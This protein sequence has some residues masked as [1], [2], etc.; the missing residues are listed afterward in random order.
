MDSVLILADIALYFNNQ[1]AEAYTVRGD[2]Y[3]VKGIHKKAIEEYDKAIKFNPNDWIAYYGKGSLYAHDDLVKWIDNFQ[4]AASL[5]HGS[6]LPFLLRGIGGVYYWAGFT[7]KGNY[8]TQEALK[9]DGD[10][11]TYY[12]SLAIGT[13]DN[14]MKNIEFHEKSYAID[15][16]DTDIQWYIG[17]NYMFLGQ[18]EEALKYFIKWIERRKVQ[19][20]H[21]LRAGMH[22]IGY[23]YWQNGYKEEAEYY[24][25]MQVEYCKGMIELGRSYAQELYPYYDL[26]GVYAF[27]G[28]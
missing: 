17:Y 7:E 22:R 6:E 11:L 3:R 1:L 23:V 26:A 9:L 25:D 27:R 28:R 18:H 14:Y 15:S 13:S 10:S 2:Y 16:T 8:Y 12:R 4:K 20:I 24:F 19:N 21:T 5:N